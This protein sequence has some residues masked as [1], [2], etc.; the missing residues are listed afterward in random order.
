MIDL[1]AL[2]RPQ[3]IADE[4]VIITADLIVLIF[5][6]TYIMYRSCTINLII[7]IAVIVIFHNTVLC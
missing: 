6:L 2:P 3:F 4:I 5:F 1:P 7:T